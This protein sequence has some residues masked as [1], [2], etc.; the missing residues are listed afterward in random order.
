MCLWEKGD[1]VPQV[2]LLNVYVSVDSSND[3][4]VLGAVRD[5]VYS[6]TPIH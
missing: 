4:V 6:R 2:H 1:S 5:P 3:H